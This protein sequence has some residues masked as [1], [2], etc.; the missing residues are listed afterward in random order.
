MKFFKKIA[1]LLGFGCMLIISGCSNCNEDLPNEITFPK[2]GGHVTMTVKNPINIYG[3]SIY[4]DVWS[5]DRIN[6]ISDD[7]LIVHQDWLTFRAKIGETKFELIA[8]DKKSD[9][10]TL[11]IF[12]TGAPDKVHSGAFI[13][14]K[15]A[16]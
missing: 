4:G 15:R 12:I 13:I 9:N 14:V 1:V 2:E 11:N 16:K 10:E 3:A 7:Y 6:E 5:D 8:D